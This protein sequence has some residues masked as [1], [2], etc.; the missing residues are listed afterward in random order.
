MPLYRFSSWILQP[1]TPKMAGRAHRS[2]SSSPE[3]VRRTDQAYRPQWT[4]PVIEPRFFEHEYPSQWYH[5]TYNQPYY[6][7]A[8]SIPSFAS[9]ESMSSAPSLPSLSS[10]QLAPSAPSVPSDT[11]SARS[12]GSSSDDVPN[13]F[14]PWVYNFRPAWPG[15]KANPI[16]ECHSIEH[17]ML[18][19]EAL[20]KFHLAVYLADEDAGENEQRMREHL[21]TICEQYMPAMRKLGIRRNQIVFF[22]HGRGVMKTGSWVYEGILAWEEKHGIAR[23][24]AKP[25]VRSWA[26]IARDGNAE[27]K[28]SS[29]KEDRNG[30][31]SVGGKKFSW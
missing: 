8:S 27:R 7:Y 19:R 5:P 14:P 15:E 24:T 20:T 11:Q 16:P 6:S 12:D 23:S 25:V 13:E 28:K 31:Y 10:P 30:A 3:K 18:V 29:V 2:K 26:Q 21:E 9:A 4:E 1:H 22:Y 17:A